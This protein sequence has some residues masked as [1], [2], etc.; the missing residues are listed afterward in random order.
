MSRQAQR[1]VQKLLARVQKLA[2]LEKSAAAIG[3]VGEARNA[4]QAACGTALNACRLILEH[5]LLVVM[6]DDLLTWPTTSVP[7]QQASNERPREAGFERGGSLPPEA[8]VKRR[9]RSRP[10]IDAETKEAIVDAAGEFAGRFVSAA[11]RDAV[12]GR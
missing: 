8:V 4:S 5:D 6:K 1:E 9:K 7:A 2:A 12:R 3:S 11:L 10:I